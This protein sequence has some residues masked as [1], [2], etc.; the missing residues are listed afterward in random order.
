MF[1]L[2]VWGS[3]VW[4]STPENKDFQTRRRFGVLLG[5]SKIKMTYCVLDL[6]TREVIDTRNVV[7]IPNNFPFRDAY[8]IPASIIRLDYETWPE[9]VPQEKISMK[10]ENMLLK[11]TPKDGFA[12]MEDLKKVQVPNIKIRRKILL[13]QPRIRMLSRFPL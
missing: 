9:L 4:F 5:L 13:I 7:S 6:E 3:G 8:K 11:I 10:V 2:L 1:Q 12:T